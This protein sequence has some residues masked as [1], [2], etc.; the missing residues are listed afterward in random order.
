MV[1]IE[2]ELCLF[3]WKLNLHLSQSKVWKQ[4]CHG[5]NH[6][7]NFL[8]MLHL[9]Y[10]IC[11]TRPHVTTGSDDC[12]GKRSKNP[13]HELMEVELLSTKQ[14]L[15]TEI[16]SSQCLVSLPLQGNNVFKV[17]G[18]I[19]E[20]DMGGMMPPPPNAFEFH[21]FSKIKSDLICKISTQKIPNFS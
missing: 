1:K 2:L 16:R 4:N 19:T 7:H 15:D 3:Y 8:G 5:L 11:K 6:K 9:C 21:K 13:G 14:T 10:Q 17:W 20:V 18:R 12:A